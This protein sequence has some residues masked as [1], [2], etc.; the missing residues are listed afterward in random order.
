MQIKMEN[1]IDLGKISRSKIKELQNVSAEL[2]GTP[3]V[4]I[5]NDHEIGVDVSNLICDME[6]LGKFKNG[7]RFTIDVSIT[8]E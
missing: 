7:D 6:I 3:Y 8:F 5:K 2:Q 1:I 4:Y